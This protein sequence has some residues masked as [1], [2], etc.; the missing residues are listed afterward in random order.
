MVAGGSS[1]TNDVFAKR[2]LF[3]E[4]TFARRTFTRRSLDCGGW[5]SYHTIRHS[6]PRRL[7]HPNLTQ[8]PR[9]KSNPPEP[10]PGR[11]ILC[12]PCARPLLNPLQP[13]TRVMY[14]GA[15]MSYKAT[16]TSPPWG[17]HGMWPCICLL[18][19]GRFRSAFARKNVTFVFYEYSFRIGRSRNIHGS[20][21][22]VSFCIMEASNEERNV[23]LTSS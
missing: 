12:L 17:D 5:V 22:D 11:G 13:R 2:C 15:R 20:S 21:L 19:F 1:V 18:R 16:S 8:R 9:T 10:P 7:R 14:S 3:L 23:H 4:D 6:T